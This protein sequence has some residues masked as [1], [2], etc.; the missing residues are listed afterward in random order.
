MQNLLR[1][2]HQIQHLHGV[3]VDYSN[4]NVAKQIERSAV[5]PCLNSIVGDMKMFLELG[6]GIDS[7]EISPFAK[8]FTDLN[9]L[10]STY[11]SYLPQSIRNELSSINDSTSS[12][13]SVN[14]NRSN[15][16]IKQQ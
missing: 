14:G 4:Q 13:T 6:L 11:Y 12:A 16:L 10:A 5:E 15:L 2:L 9:D 8:K 1:T 3:D 7:D